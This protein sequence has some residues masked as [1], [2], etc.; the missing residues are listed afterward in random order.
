MGGSYSDFLLCLNTY[1]F[2]KLE[3][4]SNNYILM[5]TSMECDNILI[6]NNSDNWL[7]T[8]VWNFSDKQSRNYHPSSGGRRG[9]GD[10]IYFCNLNF[11][12]EAAGRG[13]RG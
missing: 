11:E 6:M 5:A 7:G 13:L 12:E 9:R 2:Q 1:N 4:L 10:K 3:S 8:A